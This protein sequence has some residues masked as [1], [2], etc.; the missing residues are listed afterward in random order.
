MQKPQRIPD[1]MRDYH[2]TEWEAE[3]FS[4]ICSTEILP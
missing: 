3:K 1:I 4:F 2:V